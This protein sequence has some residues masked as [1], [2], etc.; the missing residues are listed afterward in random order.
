MTEKK[1]K[2][3]IGEARNVTGHYFGDMA[4]VAITGGCLGGAVGAIVGGL[5]F[6]DSETGAVMGTAV[7][8][9]VVAT[10]SCIVADN[11]LRS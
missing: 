11:I 2:C 4:A 10:G 3:T 9:G 7:G 8:A 1:S 5:A 6:G